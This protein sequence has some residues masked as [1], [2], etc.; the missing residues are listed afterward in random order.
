MQRFD[1]FLVGFLFILGVITAFTDDYARAAYIIVLA[2]FVMVSDLWLEYKAKEAVR[3][4]IAQEEKKD[5][6]RT[7]A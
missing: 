2:I 5:D 3:T 6:S 1:L 4:V 7:L